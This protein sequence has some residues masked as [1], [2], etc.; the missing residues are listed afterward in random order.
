MRTLIVS[1]D[2]PDDLNTRVHGVFK[3]QE[4]F[5]EAFKGFGAL[6]CLFYVEPRI[7]VSPASVDRYRAM[8]AEHYQ[9]DLTL[10]LVHRHF[11]DRSSRWEAYGAGIFDAYRQYDFRPAAGPDQ[12]AAL[13]QA[14]DRNPDL[15]FVHRLRSMAA[16]S[17]ARRPLPP[18]FFDLDDVEHRAFARSIPHP[19]TWPGKRL[20]YL[21]LPALWLAERSAIAKARR[22][23]VCAEGDRESL[24][25]TMRVD[26]VT[27]IPNSVVMPEP[28]GPAPDPTVMFLGMLSYAPNRN[29]AAYLAEDI[30]PRVRE[31]VP[32]AQLIIA[33]SH[34]E[35]VPGFPGGEGVTFTGFVK[36]LDDLY[37]R[38]RVVCVPIRTGGG[39]R[40]KIIEAASYGRP[41]VSTTIG[42]EGLA[43][44]DGRDILLRDSA[45]DFA[46]ALADL[47]VNEER[48]HELG[49]AAREAVL[50]K[51][52]R[53]HVVGQIQEEV[54]QTM[55][56]RRNVGKVL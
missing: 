30:W 14:L 52:A 50:H 1:M 10:S 35:Q 29:A 23:F 47:L 16:V 39:T 54:S 36:D 20:Y 51:Y 44:E 32:N 26:G 43:M 49:F 40:F 27:V 15:L 19:P 17:R 12:V 41:T 2:F 55:S 34:P 5:V 25:R 11:P 24:T 7:D 18:M 46:K 45:E 13:E 31:A 9:A 53:Q 28:C 3:R 21:Q 56:A 8:L 22:T 48:A 42:A 4:M 33:G 37:A 38:T 6:E